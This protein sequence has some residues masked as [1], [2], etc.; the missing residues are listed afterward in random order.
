LKPLPA[1]RTILNILFDSEFYHGRLFKSWKVPGFVKRFETLAPVEFERQ[2]ITDITETPSPQTTTYGV[3]K[4]ERAGT[5]DTLLSG[6][7]LD[8]VI[9]LR[10][11]L[12]SVR[13]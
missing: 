11:G 9:P 7:L 13:L 3:E 8:P 2:N 4:E 5:I 1:R 6:P 12:K 10:L